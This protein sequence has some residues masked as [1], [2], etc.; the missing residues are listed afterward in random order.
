[1]LDL[2]MHKE[3]DEMMHLD[4]ITE[5]QHDKLFFVPVS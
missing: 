1:M 5:K 2:N 3:K 4:D